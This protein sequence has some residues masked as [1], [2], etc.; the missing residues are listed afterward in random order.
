MSSNCKGQKK[1]RLKDL[2]G[3]TFIYQA[4]LKSSLTMVYVAFAGGQEASVNAWRITTIELFIHLKLVKN[5]SVKTITHI[6]HF[7]DL[8]CDIDVDNL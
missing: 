8:F 1:K 3:N 4:M 5:G 6:N 7:K 2:D